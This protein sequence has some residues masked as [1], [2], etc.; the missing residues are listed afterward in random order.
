MNQKHREEFLSW[1]RFS[2]YRQTWV[3][4]L[5]YLFYTEIVT[6]FSSYKKSRCV[7]VDLFHWCTSKD[8]L[9]MPVTFVC[10]WSL[11]YFFHF[12]FSFFC[13]FC[14]VFVF[15]F[16]MFI[17]HFEYLT[18]RFFFFFFLKLDFFSSP[19]ET[20]WDQ[21]HIFFVSWP[22]FLSISFSVRKYEYLGT[23]C[24]SIIQE[25]TC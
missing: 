16:L 19:R 11:F 12:Y 23:V 9:L 7:L 20:F 15:A 10:F 4:V 3:N 2:G 21:R 6:N 25:Q 1:Q 22:A 18:V 5:W 17:E 14:F 8:L 13:F 24:F